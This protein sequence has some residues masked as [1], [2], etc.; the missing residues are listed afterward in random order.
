MGD[1][2]LGRARR[3]TAWLGPVV[4]VLMA[5]GAQQAGAVDGMAVS[6][7]PD[8]SSNATV[9]MVRVGAQ[10]KWNK[11]LLEGASWH[12]GGYWGLQ[13]G[14]WSN[15]S[16]NKTNSGLWEMAFTPVFRVQQNQLSDF[17]PYAEIGVGAHLLSE[18]S[19]STHRQ[20]GTAF[21]FGSHAGV[22]ARFGEKKEFD[23]SYRYQHLSNACIE[24]P[25]N[26]INFH[27]LRLGYWFK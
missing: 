14:Y 6:S 15:S 3:R 24:E 20:F 16:P 26:G 1:L 21:Q 25:N 9:D 11:R 13:A 5:G 12:L 4:A 18:T 10:W 23:I 27:I 22:G 19:V 17:A 7:G 8:A 2:L